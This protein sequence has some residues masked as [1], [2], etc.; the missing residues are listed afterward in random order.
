[1]CNMCKDIE[2]NKFVD[3]TGRIFVNFFGSG[4]AL[5]PGMP[6]PSQSPSP[7]Q[8]RATE[9]KTEQQNNEHKNESQEI[10]RNNKKYGENMGKIWGNGKTNMARKTLETGKASLNKV[11]RPMERNLR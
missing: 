1:M 9:E 7:T 11:N 3:G 10:T 6:K 4:T 2:N 5:G 8:Q